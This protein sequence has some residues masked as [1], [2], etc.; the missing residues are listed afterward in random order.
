ME[1]FPFRGFLCSLMAGSRFRPQLHSTC[2]ISVRLWAGVSV[3]LTLFDIWFGGCCRFPPNPSTPTGTRL[4]LS[5]HHDFLASVHFLTWMFISN[6]LRFSGNLR[7]NMWRN[8]SSPPLVPFSLWVSTELQ[9][10]R[11]FFSSILKF[12]SS[13]ARGSPTNF[14]RCARDVRA[15]KMC[16]GN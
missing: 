12:L 15:P 3:C 4:P 13:P 16:R 11:V 7:K 1:L 9:Q 8:F 2:R 14:M 5:P 6:D 10:F